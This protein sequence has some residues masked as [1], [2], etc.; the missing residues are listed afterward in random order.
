MDIYGHLSTIKRVLLCP[1][2]LLCS[3]TLTGC[4]LFYCC[5]YWY[6]N[7]LDGCIYVAFLMFAGNIFAGNGVLLKEEIEKDSASTASAVLE[8]AKK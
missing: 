2:W 5:V 3:S 7:R 1:S 8:V 4:F 6:E